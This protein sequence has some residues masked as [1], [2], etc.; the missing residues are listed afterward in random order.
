[1]LIDAEGGSNFHAKIVNDQ[2]DLVLGARN[3]SADTVLTSQRDA[4]FKTGSSETERM[5]I[6]SNGHL[7]FGSVAQQEPR[8]ARSIIFT[9]NTNGDI[10][11]NH[12]TSNTSGDVYLTFGYNGSA[13]GSVTQTAPQQFSTNTTS[14]YRLKENVVDLDGNHSRQATCS[15]AFQLHR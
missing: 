2:G 8:P 12:S 11:V 10:S 14:D 6:A 5:R 4:L 13:I 15:E 1:M 9:I 3:T 7:A